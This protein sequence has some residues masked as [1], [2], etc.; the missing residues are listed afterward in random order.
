[1]EQARALVDT[2]TEE[3][4]E[5]PIPVVFTVFEGA[6]FASMDRIYFDAA[7]VTPLVVIHE[8]AHMLCGRWR[9][10]EGRTGHNGRTFEVMCLAA[11]ALEAA[12]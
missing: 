1:M 2:I 5:D 10:N 3:L 4:G 6:S 9:I 12:L 7:D 8:T 11:A